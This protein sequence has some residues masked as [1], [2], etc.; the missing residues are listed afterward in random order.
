M[1]Q[2]LEAFEDQIQPHL[3]ANAAGDIQS[4]KALVRQRIQA[5]ANDACDVVGLGDNHPNGVAQ[6]LR[7]RI[8]PT[9][10]P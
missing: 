10:R 6:D 3:S 4:F 5:L 9:G 1:A 2:V 7:D 8:S